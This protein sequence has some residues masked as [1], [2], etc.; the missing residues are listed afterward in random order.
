MSAEPERTRSSVENDKARKNA[1]RHHDDPN[2]PLSP[3]N[4]FNPLNPVG[5]CHMDSPFK[6]FSM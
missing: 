5:F 1:Q 4:A 3:Y 2:D 6:I